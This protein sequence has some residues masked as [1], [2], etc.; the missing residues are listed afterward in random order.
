MGSVFFKNDDEQPPEENEHIA[1][2]ITGLWEAN[3]WQGEKKPVD[4]FVAKG[5]LEGLFEKL[6]FAEHIVYRQAEIKYASRTDCGNCT[7]W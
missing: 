5:Y 7:K 3:L 2:A 4:F 1:G 6:G